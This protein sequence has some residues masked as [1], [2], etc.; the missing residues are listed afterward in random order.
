MR[1]LIVRTPDG[2]KVAVP[3]QGHNGAN[4]PRQSTD[5]HDGA[6]VP[7]PVRRPDR[8][9]KLTEDDVREAR[10]MHAAGRFGVGDLAHIYDVSQ[11]NMSAVINGKTWRHLTAEPLPTEQES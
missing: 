9:A 2:R 6:P 3:G 4:P 5:D 10:A 8:R 11:S 7:T 1:P